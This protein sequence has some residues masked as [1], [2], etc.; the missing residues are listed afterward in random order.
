MYKLFAKICRKLRHWMYQALGI[1]VVEMSAE[2]S[3]KHIIWETGVT[4]DLGVIA[5][6]KVTSAF[7][8]YL[9]DELQSYTGIDSFSWHEYGTS[10]GAENKTDTA[11]TTAIG[12]RSTGTQTEGASANIYRTVGTIT[13][14]GT[15]AITEHGIFSSSSS[16][17]LMDRS[18]FSAIN[19]SSGDSIEF[20]YELTANAED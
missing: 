17:T 5:R 14:T 15:H 20:T 12:T 7:V 3:A 11:L 1:G 19:V 9:V 16:G 2:L 10:T 18:L 6:K 13:A 8:N 4:R